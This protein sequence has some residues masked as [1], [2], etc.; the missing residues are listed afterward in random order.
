MSVGLDTKPPARRN[1]SKLAIHMGDSYLHQSHNSETIWSDAP[2]VPVDTNP[3]SIFTR[4]V[5]GLFY[6]PLDSIQEYFGKGVA[7]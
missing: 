5:V 1:S 2:G 7:F 4:V 6:Q 3:P